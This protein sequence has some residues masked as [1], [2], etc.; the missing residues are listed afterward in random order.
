M[1]QCCKRSISRQREAAVLARSVDKLSW[2][3]ANGCP[4]D[5]KVLLVSA[6]KSGSIAALEW[7]KR[8]GAADRSATGLAPALNAA[9]VNSKLVAAQ[10][11]KL[12]LVIVKCL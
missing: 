8:S 2:L 9:A 4:H 1:L 5:W 12:T 7:L 3:L 6:A 11:H 10:V